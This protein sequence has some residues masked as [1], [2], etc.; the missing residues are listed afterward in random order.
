MELTRKGS[1]S[2]ERIFKA[3]V[4]VFARKGY[5]GT[6]MRELAENARVNPAMIN[7]FFGSKKELLKVILDTFF[8]G[9][10]EILEEEMT[11]SADLNRKIRCF[12]HR[13]VN[14][15]AEHRDYMVI[16]LT[17]LPHDDPEITE[18]KAQWAG[19]AMRIIQEEI[20]APLKESRGVH[21]SPAAVGPLLFS[22]MSS[23]FL[24]APVIEQLR[25]PGYGEEYLE[26][27][28]DIIAGIFLD[29]LNGLEGEEKGEENG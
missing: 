9:Y 23:R 8:T 10:L 22:M 2:K 16:T 13:A 29:G 7:Y 18:Y 12:I 28:P 5:A 17:E 6:G 24:S 19:K 27:Y 1:A 14:Y 26:K 21:L 3:A 4:E 15:I 25:P 11:G 20:C